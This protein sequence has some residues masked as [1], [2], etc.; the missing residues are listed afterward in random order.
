MELTN[1]LRNAN[2]QIRESIPSDDIPD[3]VDIMIDDS[4]KAQASIADWTEEKIDALLSD[5]ANAVSARA[6]EFAADSVKES[7]LGVEAHKIQKIKLAAQETLK[8]VLDQPAGGV[9]MVDDDKKL[10]EIAA[11]MGVVLGLIPLTNPVPTI[12]FKTL[13]SLKTRNSLV[14]SCHRNALGVGGKVGELIQSVLVDHGADPNLVQWI[15]KRSSRRTTNI[16]MQHRDV[17]LILATG[18]PGMVSAAYSSG[19]PAIGVGCG[20]AP[21]WIC[22]DAD[23]AAAAE[24]I[25]GS[26]SFDNGVICGSENNLVVDQSRRKE[27]IEALKASGAAVL[28]NDEILRFEKHILDPSTNG[29]KREFVGKDAAGM[30]SGAGIQRDGDIKLVVVPVDQSMISEA[31]GGE[32]LAPIL[33]MFTVYNEDEGM[34]F[35]SRILDKM[36]AGHTAIIHTASVDL[37]E[38]YGLKMPASRILHNCPGS[39]GCIGIGNSL[40]PS[41]TLGCGSWGNTSTTDNVG[42]DNLMNVKRIVQPL[43]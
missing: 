20:N 41:F 3:W 26:K 5:I 36:G 10:T 21:V 25:V 38:R 42:Y 18:G 31:W 35:C 23:V 22:S 12:T 14:L 16:F 28:S 9:I 2:T 34:D 33:S 39:T 7:G 24:A 29:L 11:P 30:L 40:R 32:M 4:K 17:S 13:I 1:K 15:K 27:F 6:E 8:T 37:A 19:T 43:G